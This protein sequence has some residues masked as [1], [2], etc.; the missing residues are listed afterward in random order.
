MMWKASILFGQLW[1]TINWVLH[2]EFKCAN[3]SAGYMNPV[4][5]FDATSGWIL[6][7]TKGRLFYPGLKSRV[8]R[9]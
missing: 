2:R 6:D 8:T 4:G 5:A 1:V 3:L 7:G 9:F